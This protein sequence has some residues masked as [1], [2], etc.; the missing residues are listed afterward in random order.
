ML[1]NGALRLF[2]PSLLDT[3]S[4]QVHVHTS[5][6]PG[7]AEFSVRDTGCGIGRK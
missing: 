7:W 2:R 1:S 3:L 6:R 4:G 5:Y